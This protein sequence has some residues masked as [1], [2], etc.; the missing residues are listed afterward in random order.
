MSGG[1]IDVR[2]R[3][4]SDRMSQCGARTN[5]QKQA[6]QASVLNELLKTEQM[7][8]NHATIHEESILQGSMNKISTQIERN[9]ATL[10]GL[11][12]NMV[13][14][15]NLTKDTVSDNFSNLKTQ[16]QANIMAIDLKITEGYKNQLA[17]QKKHNEE[18]SLD[19]RMNGGKAL[20]SIRTITGRYR[21]FVETSERSVV[22]MQ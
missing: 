5:Y 19:I 18:R 8:D 12:Q 6:I 9:F 14:Q 16:E 1:P 10:E 22:D 4:I 11:Q 17:T 21:D 7:A 2:Y 15:L 20:D 3:K 13:Q